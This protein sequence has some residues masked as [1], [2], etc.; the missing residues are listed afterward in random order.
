M[1]AVE[2]L[3]TGRGDVVALHK[4]LGEVLG[5]FEYGTSLGR[6]DDGNILRTLVLLQVIID[7]LYQRVFGTDD[8]HINLVVDDKLLDG[9]EIVGLHGHVF[10]AIAGTGISWSNV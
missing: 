4:G 7:T 2:G 1:F 5:A 10:A 3:V 6:T 8:H 9:L